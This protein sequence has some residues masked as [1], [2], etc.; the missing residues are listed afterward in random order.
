MMVDFRLPGHVVPRNRRKRFFLIPL[1]VFFLSTGMTAS[2]LL[3]PLTAFSSSG[4]GKRGGIFEVRRQ[5][6]N[7]SPEK[8]VDLGKNCRTG[9]RIK[10]KP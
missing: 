3:A 10:K 8:R 7:P 2:G 6:A 4:R 1:H 5:P 9:V